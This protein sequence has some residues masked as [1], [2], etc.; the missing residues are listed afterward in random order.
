MRNAPRIASLAPL[1]LI[2]L[3]ISCSVYDEQ[4][5][6][7]VPS[8]A[9]SGSGATG[10]I[11]G[12]GAASGG[13]GGGPIAGAGNGATG[14]GATG[15]SGTAGD[16][17]FDAGG[18]PVD[19]ETPPDPACADGAASCPT[20]C[21]EACDG[22]DNDCDGQTDEDPDGDI[23]RLPNAETACV[24]G[25]CTL[26]G[27]LTLYGNC[28]G[29]DN[30]GCETPLDTLTDC[31]ACEASCARDNAAADC[32]GGICGITSC[33]SGYDNCDGDLSNGC[34]HD[35][36]DG[37]CTD[38]FPYPPSNFNPTLL[39]RAAAPDVTL[40]CAAVFDSS[41]PSGFAQWCGQPA[42]PVSVNDSQDP[43]AVIL[44][45]QNLTVTAA[46]SLTL[47]GDKPVILAVFGSAVVD[48][49]IDASANGPVPGAGGDRSCTDSAGA[50]GQTGLA[51]LENGGGG[52]GGF[53]TAGG[54]GGNTV[55][56][57]GGNGGVSRGTAALVPL[58]GG[59]PGGSGGGATCD[60]GAGGGAVQISVGGTLTVTGT[61]RAHGG[62]GADGCTNDAGGAGGGSGGAILLEGVT[63]TTDGAPLSANGGRGGD[64]QG[65]GGG[66]DGSVDG[67]ADGSDG[68]YGLTSGGGGGGGGYGRVVV[69]QV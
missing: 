40:D 34:E 32:A 20:V 21:P 61:I 66:G 37:P 15:G 62:D 24:E 27:C 10:G 31:G 22:E 67:G 33:N 26:T 17:G 42:P 58:L 57:T 12:G 28:D 3:V 25:A 19:A 11:S 7:G 38:A 1:I 59:C 52:G 49:V 2:L 35:L 30:N 69:N 55:L 48:G 36:N 4:L 47:I 45:L 16:P 54:A 63:V 44:A 14:G 60:P 51:A 43:P 29:Q 53:G 18:E 50:E 23:C 9:G 46:G 39:D 5:L 41:N 8:G 68:G 13:N 6:G 65:G 64:G 56:T